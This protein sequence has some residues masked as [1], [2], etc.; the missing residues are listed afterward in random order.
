MLLGVKDYVLLLKHSPF[1]I[2]GLKESGDFME[3]A[4]RTHNLVKTYKGINVVD[5]LNINIKKGEIYG[6]LGQNGAGKTTTIRMIMGLIKASKG[7]IEL[8][9]QSNYSKDIYKRI[10]ATIEYPGF[11]P[12]LTAVENLDIHRRMMNIEN[13]EYIKESLE[14]VGLD[15]NEIKKKKVK[16]YSLGMKQRLGIARAI[17][18]KPELL[19][20][21]EPTNGLDPLGIK[22]VREILIDLRDKK[23]ITILASSHLLSEVE[24]L[25]TDIGV[26][27]KGRLL[28]EIDYKA[29][30][31]RNRK[32]FMVRVNDDNKACFLLENKLNIKDFEVV[33]KNILRI[34]EG[35][36]KGAQIAKMFVNNDIDLHEIRLS[37]DNLEDYFVK[38][39]GGNE[40]V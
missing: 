4:I 33:E 3:Y 18:H 36:D 26:I 39:T 32:Y 21:D 15:L 1:K 2:I 16:N 31:K 9:G 17:L 37:V 19:I 28:E 20:L 23:G 7:E 30:Q 6:F 22:D 27:H 10:G 12:N 34:Y 35:L 29:L 11:Y 38:L 5:S 13:K 40:N 8:F 25:A 14:I 24:H